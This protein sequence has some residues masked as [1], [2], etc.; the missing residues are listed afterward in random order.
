[1]NQRNVV[2]K[3]TT[4]TRASTRSTD[5]TFKYF[6]LHQKNDFAG[7]LDISFFAF[8]PL[9]FFL[10]KLWI[11]SNYFKFKVS[12]LMLTRLWW[13]QISIACLYL[14][15]AHSFWC[16][17]SAKL[18]YFSS[19]F[20][21]NIFKPLNVLLNVCF[22]SE[23]SVFSLD[24]SRYLLQLIGQLVVARLCSTCSRLLEYHNN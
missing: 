18:L 21:R 23:F 4:C 7:V 20:C 3:A 13:I 6:K 19:P 5:D 11:Y 22:I 9:T 14:C 10:Q 2:D 8:F 24:W 1:M 12:C 15:L 16:V 17:L